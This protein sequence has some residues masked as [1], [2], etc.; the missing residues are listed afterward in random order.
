MGLV[1]G[2]TI[3]RIE[4]ILVPGTWA[5]GH[6][7]FLRNRH[8]T[9]DAHWF[10]KDSTFSYRLTAALN[11][12][13]IHSHIECHD[14]SGANSVRHRYDA[15]TRLSA[16]VER[17]KASAD[18]PVQVIIAH[19]HG[20]TVALLAMRQLQERGIDINDVLVVTMATPFVEMRMAD[21]PGLGAA[22]TGSRRYGVLLLSALMV[23]LYLTRLFPSSVTVLSIGAYVAGALVL[24]CGSYAIFRFVDKLERARAATRKERHLLTLTSGGMHA[25][26]MIGPLVIRGINDEAALL[27]AAGTLASKISDFFISAYMYFYLWIFGF[28]FLPVVIIDMRLNFDEPLV[29]ALTGYLSTAILAVGAPIIGAGIGSLAVAWICRSVYGREFFFAPFW[30][31]VWAQSSPDT[32]GA[33]TVITLPPTR[34]NRSGLRHSIHEHERVIDSI[35][36]WIQTSLQRLSK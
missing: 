21:H 18:K 17:R 29:H 33:L 5:R 11:D 34:R 9:R 35:A 19:S 24:F 2:Q 31:E 27:L 22:L 26:G 7:G 23:P 14:W 13:E 3:N 20:G 1:D 30:Y 16:L 6:F 8:K 32:D 36:C 12:L 10:E 4:V 25:S 28:V 15:A